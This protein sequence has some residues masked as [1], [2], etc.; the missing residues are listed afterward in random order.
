M[1]SPLQIIIIS[2]LTIDK[3]PDLYKHA[4]LYVFTSYCETFGLTS[5]EAM[6]QGTPVVISNKSALPEIN[7]KAALYFDP[8]NINEI[9]NTL[10]QVLYDKNLRLKLIKKGFNLVNKYKNKKNIK[11]TINII[12][13]FN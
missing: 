5:L 9:Y 7:L 13:N 2:N 12:N 11:E 8:D 1:I 3:L 4:E 10:R 6:S